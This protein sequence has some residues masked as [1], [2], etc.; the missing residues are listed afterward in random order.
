MSTM[1]HDHLGQWQH[2]HTSTPKMTKMV[3]RPR[4]HDNDDETPMDNTAMTTTAS[5]VDHQCNRPSAT[6][7]TTTSTS[8]VNDNAM[9]MA[10]AIAK[11]L[12]LLS[13]TSTTDS[14]SHDM[15]DDDVT[16][17]ANATVKTMMTLLLTTST[18]DSQSHNSDHH[19]HQ[20]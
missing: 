8:N 3:V 10:N 13:T 7:Q 4:Q 19:H 15:D 2:V 16:C 14:Q 20:Q 5:I 18:T 9:H 17:M 11:M 6:I 12:S 1:Y